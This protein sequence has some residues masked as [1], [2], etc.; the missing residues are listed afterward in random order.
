[1]APLIEVPPLNNCR[2]VSSIAS[3]KAFTLTP[4]SLI[5]VQGITWIC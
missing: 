4:A 5:S 2:G 3:A 1:M